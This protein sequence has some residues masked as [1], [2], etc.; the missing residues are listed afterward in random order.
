M[1]IRRL[2]G[3]VGFILDISIILILVGMYYR[4][5]ISRNVVTR[6]YLIYRLLWTFYSACNG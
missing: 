5:M 1:N 6:V 2:G 3:V 4:V